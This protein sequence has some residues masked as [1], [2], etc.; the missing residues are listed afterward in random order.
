MPRSPFASSAPALRPSAACRATA[1]AMRALRPRCA[2]GRPP[3]IELTDGGAAAARS[4]SYAALSDY[5]RCGYRFLVERVIGL[6]RG[7]EASAPATSSAGS[8][9]RRP[10]ADG[11][12]PG[13][14]L[15]ARVERAQRLERARREPDRRRPRAR[16]R[17]RERRR[18]PATRSPPGSGRTCWPSCGTAGRPSALRSPSGSSSERTR[19]CAAR[20]TC[21]RRRAG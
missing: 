15:P 16:G 5:R 19:C 18:E 17:R 11:L 3:L 2:S 13:R 10:A 8:D 20:S 7:Y 14:P 4:L 6:G 1:A 9:R 21:W 12:R